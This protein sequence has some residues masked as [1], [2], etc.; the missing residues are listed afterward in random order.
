ME[1]QFSRTLGFM[2]HPVRL[3]ILRDVATIEP[4]LPVLDSCVGLFQARLSV[5]KALDLGPGQDDSR[6]DFLQQFE[7]ESGSAVSGDDLHRVDLVIPL[8]LVLRAAALGH[9]RSSRFSVWNRRN[10]DFKGRVSNPAIGPRPR[11]YG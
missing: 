2:V 10:Q 3:E 7:L 5:A 8:G 11:S 6:L 4:D 9:C 1:Q